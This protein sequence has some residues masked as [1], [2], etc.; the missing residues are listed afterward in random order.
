MSKIRVQNPVVHTP[1]F[2]EIV[3]RSSSM[4]NRLNEL[5]PKEVYIWDS[6]YWFVCHEDWG[7]IITDVLLN[8]PKYTVGKFDCEN[9]ALLTSARVSEKYHLN[10]MGIVI[11]DSPQGRHGWNIFLSEWGL[12]YLEPQTGEVFSVKDSGYSAEI[13]I[14]G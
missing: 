7:I 3:I 11:G 5:N 8:M 1:N 6:N 9:F 14:M 2:S 4:R 13:I 12:H 10:T